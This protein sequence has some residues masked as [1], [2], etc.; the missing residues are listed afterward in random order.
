HNP[1]KLAEVDALVKKYEGNEELLF[2]RLH[3]K[4]NAL[5]PGGV[6]SIAAPPGKRAV[7]R[8]FDES[9]FLYEEEEELVHFEDEQ[10]QD[11]DN[12]ESGSANDRSGVC[13]SSGGSDNDEGFEVVKAPLSPPSVRKLSVGGASASE[14]DAPSTPTHGVAMTSLKSA[15]VRAAIE[16]ARRAQEERVQQRIAQ[17][18][19]RAAR[20]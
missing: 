20:Q 19:A 13:G 15:R 6:A 5:G 12:E 8:E 7:S 10:A 18:A 11:A 1:E 9:A 14:F 17:L 3:R 2:T 16:E 4:Y